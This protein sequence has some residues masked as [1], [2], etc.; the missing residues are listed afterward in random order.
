MRSFS[1]P[2]GRR[3]TNEVR[4]TGGPARRGV[5]RRSY[6]W[7]T[8]VRIILTSLLVGI[9]TSSAPAQD[10]YPPNTYL[11]IVGE[12]GTGV[13]TCAGVEMLQSWAFVVRTSPEP[14]SLVV[15]SLHDP[16]LPVAV[17]TYSLPEGAQHLRAQGN[18]L[19][20]TSVDGYDAHLHIWDATD[21]YSLFE[22]GT[23][24]IDSQVLDLE[25]E[26]ELLALCTPHFH[27]SFIN[28]ADPANIYEADV[29]SFPGSLVRRTTLVPSAFM[30]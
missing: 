3:K 24:F 12:S 9:L 23:L 20:F 6:R 29:L 2:D 30:T 26:G 21:P 28:V 1:H 10:C 17:A 25:V 27:L 11:P 15:W 22:L 13:G 5:V 16:E 8:I 7:D 4:Q 14:R 18:R 19:Y